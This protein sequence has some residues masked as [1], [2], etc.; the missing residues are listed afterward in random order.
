M[1]YR[2]VEDSKKMICPIARISGNEPTKAKCVAGDCM[3]WRWRG[4]SAMDARFQGAVSREVS[5]LA[6]ENPKV[7]PDLL[8]KEAV[9]RVTKDP[10][11]YTF[12]DPEVDLGFC[13]LGGPP[14][15]ATTK[16]QAND[17]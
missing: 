12:P 17:A 3:F 10:M 16:G 8:H 6:S 7:K 5:F 1:T 14:E 13:G 4:M 11:A 15:H 9:K 2:T